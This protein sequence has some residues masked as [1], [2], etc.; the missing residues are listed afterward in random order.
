MPS[1]YLFIAS[2]DVDGAKEAL[3]NEVYDTEHCPSLGKLDGVGKI[4]RFETQ[5]FKVLISGET[6]TIT[7]DEQPRFHAMYEVESPEVLTSPEW[8]T[9]VDSGRWAEH[10]RPFT[11]NR[12]HTLLRLVYP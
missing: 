2:M 8:A 4:A 10:V 7:P 12:Q 3:F 6:K 11:T 5:P 9:A 1:K